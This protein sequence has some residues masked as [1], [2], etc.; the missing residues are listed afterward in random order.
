M[1]DDDD[2]MDLA[3]VEAERQ[4]H[5]AAEEA[6][7]RQEA[8]RD[9]LLRRIDEQASEL[10]AYRVLRDEAFKWCRADPMVAAAG[11][12]TSMR[13]DAASEYGPSVAVLTERGLPTRAALSVAIEVAREATRRLWLANPGRPILCGDGDDQFEI[14][15]ISGGPIR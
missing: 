1:E 3:D 14:R 4:R 6:E 2:V 13:S 5:A 12:K 7:W 8:T 11:A 15:R 10:Q 9:E